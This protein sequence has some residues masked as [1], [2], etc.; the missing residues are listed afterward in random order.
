MQIQILPPGSQ[1]AMPM[2]PKPNIDAIKQALPS[3]SNEPDFGV[4]RKEILPQKAN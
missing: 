3:K 4:V 1:G 2:T